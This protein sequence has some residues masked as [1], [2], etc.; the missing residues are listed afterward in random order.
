MDCWKTEGGHRRIPRESVE[1]LLAKPESAKFARR[2]RTGSGNT[3]RVTP[4]R[5]FV[6]DD[7]LALLR[8]YQL[9]V[10]DWSIAPEV[11]T[12]NNG[13]ESLLQLGR[14]LPD[15]LI[16]DLNMPQTDGFQVLH[17]IRAMPEFDSLEIVVVTGIGQEEISARGGLPAGI[18]VL[19][20]PIP[21]HQ[22]EHIAEQL[23][24]RLSAAPASRG[25]LA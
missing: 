20:K 18:Q 23:A 16:T 10:S 14:A 5:I 15:L 13:I 17:A 2:T 7:D 22:L 21:F 3:A 1:R 12:V 4:L 6:L 8:L 9:R 19:P 11:T 25:R 24:V